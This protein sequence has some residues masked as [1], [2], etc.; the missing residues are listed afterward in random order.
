MQRRTRQ[1]VDIEVLDEVVDMRCISVDSPGSLYLAG[2]QMV[3]SHNTTIAVLLI[4]WYIGMFPDRQVIFISYSDGYSTETGRLVRDLFKAHGERFFGLTVDRDNDS[5]G[6]WSLVG[7]P[8][9]GMLSVGIGGQITGRQG[10]LVWIDDIL[11][12]MEEAAS[13]TVKDGHWSAWQG[14]I[15]G[16]RQPGS[17]YVVASTCLANDDLS[18]RLKAQQDAGGGIPWKRL[19]YPGICYAP[20][21]YEGDPAEYRSGARGTAPHPVLPTGRHTGEQLVAA[22]RNPVEEPSTV[23][24]HDPAEPVE[25]GHRDVPGRPVGEDAARRLAGTIRELQ[26]VGYRRDRG[27]R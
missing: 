23:R 2:R 7:H 10:H 1:I 25:L 21:D 15:W 17:T 27:R 16:R 20:E 12:T 14:A 5:Q 6:D 13:A 8:S 24:V 4:F 3:P 18:G 19:V 11:K 9:G 22:R 26:G